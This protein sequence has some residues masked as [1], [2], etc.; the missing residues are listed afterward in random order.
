MNSE[1]I[2]LVLKEMFKSGELY[3]RLESDMN[4]VYLSVELGGEE[5]SRSD[6]YL[7]DLNVEE[8]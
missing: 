5:L 8:Y 6:I 3:L 7:S 4:H 2:K 1:S